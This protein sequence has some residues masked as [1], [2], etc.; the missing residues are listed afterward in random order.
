MSSECAWGLCEW[1]EDLECTC[2]CHDMEEE[3][4]L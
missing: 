3:D 2:G 1:C 4:Q